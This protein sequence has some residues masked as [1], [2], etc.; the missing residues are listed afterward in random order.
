MKTTSEM[1]RHSQRSTDDCWES[2]RSIIHSLRGS[3]SAKLS[4]DL[5]FKNKNI[6]QISQKA[7]L[8]NRKQ[9]KQK[10]LYLE[11]TS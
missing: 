11:A 9:F 5:L 1:R 4:H 10:L 8:S 2:P 7:F 6:N 3:M